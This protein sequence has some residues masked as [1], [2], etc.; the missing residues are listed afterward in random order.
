MA[1]RSCVATRIALHGAQAKNTR[2]ASLTPLQTPKRT[3]EGTLCAPM[4]S[5]ETVSLIHVPGGSKE[6]TPRLRYARGEQAPIL[7]HRLQRSPACRFKAREVVFLL[8]MVTPESTLIP[9][10]PDEAAHG[11]TGPASGWMVGDGQ[12][13]GRSTAC[14]GHVEQWPGSLLVPCKWL[15]AA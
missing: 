13:L 11:C 7:R 15:V 14:P 3:R 6:K 1:L 4:P 5:G 10:H 8:I 12:L 9:H 2:H